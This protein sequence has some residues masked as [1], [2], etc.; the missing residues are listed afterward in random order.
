MFVQ[1]A[2]KQSGHLTWRVRQV[3]DVARSTETGA[4]TNIIYGLALG[5]Q[6][7]TRILAATDHLVV[8]G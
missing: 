8:D 5:Y 4:A 6:V 2:E 7:M 1:G 3:R